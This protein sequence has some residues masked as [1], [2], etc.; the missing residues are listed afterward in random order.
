MKKL[1]VIGNPIEFS[2][3]PY[4]HHYFSKLTSI[5]VEYSKIQVEESQFYQT[6]ENF[7]SSHGH[8]MNVTVP[9][10]LKAYQYADKHTELAQYAKAVNTLLFE[11]S[12]TTIGHNTDGLGLINDIKQNLNWQIDG[13]KILILG[14]GGAVRGIIAPLIQENPEQI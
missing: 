3:S 6:V 13:K 4:I 7:K 11:P 10:K 12:G 14:A 8:G 2:Q 9:F 1:A 5:N